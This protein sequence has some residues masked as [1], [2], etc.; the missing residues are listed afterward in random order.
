MSASENRSADVLLGSFALLRTNLLA[1]DQISSFIPFICVVFI[2]NHIKEVNIDDLLT[3]FAARHGFC[4]PRMPMVAI[5]KACTAKKII[6]REDDGRFYVNEELAK[7]QYSL[8]YSQKFTEN[9]KKITQGFKNYTMELGFQY[10][11]DE[12]ESILLAFLRENSSKALTLRLDGFT[13]PDQ[14]K[15]KDAMLLAKYIF[16]CQ[17]NDTEIFSIIKQAAAGYLIAATVVSSIE[18]DDDYK[19][20]R[21]KY[22]SLVLYLDTPFILRVLGLNTDEMQVSYKAL[23]KELRHH[24]NAFKIFR[25]TVEEI[26]GILNDCERWIEDP[27]YNATIASQALKTFIAKKYTKVDIQLII[28]KI[29]VLL[30]D[31]HIE[32]DETDYYAEGFNYLQIN[33]APIRAAIISS[34]ME[35]NPLFNYANKQYTIECDIKSITSIFKLWRKQVYRNYTSAKFLFVTTNSTLAFLSRKFTA[36]ENPS[37]Y[38]KVYP[39]VTDVA[40]GTAIWLSE[41]VQKIDTFSEL[42]LL[43]DCSNALLPTDDVIRK[44]CDSIE[45]VYNRKQITVEDYYLLKVHAFDSELVTKQILNDESAFSDKILEE[46]LCDIKEN[47][48]APYRVQ[49]NEFK[50]LLGEKEDE[51]ETLKRRIN[52]QET[53]KQSRSAESYSKAKRKVKNIKILLFPIAIAVTGASVTVLTAVPSLDNN[54]KFTIAIILG[55]VGLSLTII[56]SLLLSNKKMNT[57]LVERYHKTIYLSLIRKEL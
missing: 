52:G 16:H 14:V 28:E 47:I 9:Y 32:I 29:D 23:L 55:I 46:I 13:I 33:D 54:I 43:A 11:Y 15:Q 50:K 57:L 40:L 2:E 51:L 45:E 22:S 26:V 41:P 24:N 35:N 38:Y 39:C 12:C 20:K 17:K 30:N 5:L 27:R 25:H 49:T 10:P 44:L 53:L 7:S 42:K 3:L 1:S 4:I 18:N 34:Y 8:N 37:Y 31:E 19:S 48:T 56:E 36:S 6:A 21:S